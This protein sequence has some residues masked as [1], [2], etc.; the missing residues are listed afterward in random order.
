[1]ISN[2]QAYMCLDHM[3]RRLSFTSR[4]SGRLNPKKPKTEPSSTPHIVFKEDVKAR[5]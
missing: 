2:N 5:K 3:S 4:V 1:M